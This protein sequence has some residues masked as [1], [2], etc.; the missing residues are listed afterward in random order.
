MSINFLSEESKDVAS[1]KINYQNILIVAIII[2][3]V[4]KR[5]VRGW[6]PPRWK[7]F[8]R[9]WAGPVP[10]IPWFH[11][12]RISFDLIWPHCLLCAI[13][14]P[15]KD[16]DVLKSVYR[17][18]LNFR[19]HLNRITFIR[20]DFFFSDICTHCSSKDTTQTT[21]ALS[22]NEKFFGFRIFVPIWCHPVTR[23]LCQLILCQFSLVSLIRQAILQWRKG[24]VC[25]LV[26]STLLCCR[27]PSQR[28]PEI[29]AELIFLMSIK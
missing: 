6:W 7:W 3:Q 1:C 16:G 25:V 11:N 5:A 2:S 15:L 21:T 12:D 19:E 29:K 17:A 9:G 27:P 22:V 14:C 8:L 18:R 24:I 4:H 23:F 28:H 20:S 10:W 26:M 13:Q